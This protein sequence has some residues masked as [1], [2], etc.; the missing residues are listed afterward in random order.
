MTTATAVREYETLQDVIDAAGG[1][2]A[3]RILLTPKPGT[4]TEADVIAFDRLDLSYE[5]VNGILL[6]KPMGNPE[7]RVAVCVSCLLGTFVYEHNLG[8]MGGAKAPLRLAP[9]LVRMPDC[10][11]T[12]WESTEDKVEGDTFQFVAPA[13]IVEVLSPHNPGNDADRVMKL[14]DYARAGVKL[15]W[16]I[17]S[18]RQLVD[19][20]PCGRYELGETHTAPDVLSGGTVLPGFTLLVSRTFEMSGPRKPK[21]KA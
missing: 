4:A 3:E 20:Y 8:V 19:V 10:C 1:V 18:V 17:D 21:K 6:K 12:P 15:V 13:L 9:G 16:Y 11:F 5:L 14:G 7:D 2:C